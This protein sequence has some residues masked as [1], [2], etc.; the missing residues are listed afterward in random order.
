MPRLTITPAGK[1]A[2]IGLSLAVFAVGLLAAYL[3]RRKNKWPRKKE[4]TDVKS[5]GQVRPTPNIDLRD[6]TS[7]ILHHWSRSSTP[8]LH[9]TSLS[10]S[11]SG[12]VIS[13]LAASDQSSDATLMNEECDVN[14]ISPYQLVNLG[15]D[16][17]ITT[18]DY[19][20]EAL[21]MMSAGNHGNHLDPLFPNATLHVPDDMVEHLEDLLAKAQ[22]IKE[23]YERQMLHRVSSIALGNAMNAIRDMDHSSIQSARICR[24]M[25]MS[26]DENSEVDSFVSATD[27]VADISDIAEQ[28]TQYQHLVL[29]KAALLEVEYGSVLCRTLRTKMLAC[30]SDTEFLAK[31][32]CVRLAFEQLFK[33]ET[34]RQWFANTGKTMIADLLRKAERDPEEFN[35]AFDEMIDYIKEEENWVDIK[36]ELKGRGVLTYTFY[37]IVLDF[38]LLDAFDDLENPPSSVT[39]VVQNR[40]LSNGFKE[41]ALATAVWSVLKAKRRMLKIRDGFIAHFYSISEH[42]SPVL[43]WGFL[44]PNP[45]MNQLCTYF[46]DQ[47][48]GFAQDIFNFD[49]V[50]YA[51]IEQLADDILNIARHRHSLA[52]QH[53]L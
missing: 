21:E 7:T 8:R 9:T 38:I 28:K 3:R 6:G 10:R 46:K 42:V 13:A 52:S 40:W 31:L 49:K 24:R 18:M 27:E 39:T 29:Y 23:D 20:S 14:V 36:T 22:G 48:L 17:L 37:D 1:T 15:M 43:A 30:D 41:T 11:Q 12:S 16:S 33:D 44:G 45:A 53:L 50:R 34:I 2:I 19:W 35:A 4:L 5:N 32:H 25:V 51:S 26:D 47:I